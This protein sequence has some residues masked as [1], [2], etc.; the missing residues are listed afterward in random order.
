[1]NRKPEDV[2]V[3]LQVIGGYL[4]S[5]ATVKTSF[6]VHFVPYRNIIFEV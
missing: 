4:K 5:Y 2:S 1:M 3:F 6:E